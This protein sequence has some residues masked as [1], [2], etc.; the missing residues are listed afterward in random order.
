METVLEDFRQI[1]FN[2]LTAITSSGSSTVSTD[3]GNKEVT[4]FINITAAPTGTL[5]TIQFTI[6]EVDPGNEVTV[7]GTTKTGA[8]LN[9]IGTQ[10]L[11]LPVTYGGSIQVT[12]AVTGTGGPSFTGLYATLVNKGTSPAIYDQAGNGPAAVKAA[13]TAAVAT[14]PALV[15][16]ISPNN[17]ITVGAASD[18]TATGALGALNAAV[19]VT[20]PGLM[21]VGMQ[22]A[23]GTLIGTVVAESSFD[24]GTTWNQTFFD[25]PST[26]AIT[27]SLVFGSSNTATAETIVGVGGAGMTRVRVSAYTSGTAN[28]TVRASDMHDPSVL[29]AGVSGSPVPPTVALVGGTDGTNLVP[30]RMKAA[31]TAAVATDPAAVVSLS[32]NSPIPTGSNVIGSILASDQNGSGT[33]TALNASVTATTTGCSSVSFDITGTWS[34]TLTLQATNGDGNWHTISG[35]TPTSG[36][37]TNTSTF[38]SNQFVIVA[39][40][41][42]SQVRL[43]A[44]A[45]TSGTATVQWNSGLGSNYLN[46]RVS[47]N[48][49]LTIIHNNATLTTSGQMVITGVGRK[50]IC[51][52]FTL[53]GTVSGTTPSLTFL[54]EEIDPV[55]QTTVMTLPGN[56]V[57]LGPYTSSGHTNYQGMLS[58]TGA[59]LVT[60]TVTGTTPSFGGLNSWVVVKEQSLVYGLTFNGTQ[61]PLSVINID[62]NDNTIVV[63]PAASGTAPGGSPVLVG[64]WAR[65]FRRSFSRTRLPQ[66]QQLT[67]LL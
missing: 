42:Y 24:G 59:I 25:S 65:T 67:L 31:S 3:F 11:T 57:T 58:F 50:E 38:S 20:H 26:G 28:V 16:A 62:T 32:P 4:L 46:S 10:I 14:D 21:A 27:S 9:A 18:V 39:C 22:L 7:V 64:G 36:T 45:Y 15:V 44:T 49:D 47:I 56:S 63:G 13:S 43:T 53:L 1:V 5:P 41:G 55:N 37:Y 61:N 29:F 33:V 66:Q 30:I 17:P 60:W 54:V 35:A 34:A 6:Q 2:G 23:A 48:P 8:V 19:S 51:F 40:G 12:W 52:G